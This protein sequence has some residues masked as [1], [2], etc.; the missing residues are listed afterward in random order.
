[1]SEPTSNQEPT[2]LDFRGAKVL[3]AG[4]IMIDQYWIGDTSRISPEAPVPVLKVESQEHRLGGAANAAVN[5]VSLGATATLAGIH[6]DDAAGKIYQD[7]CQQHRISMLS[8]CCQSGQT[9]TKLRMI[10]NGQ[11]LMRTDFEQDFSTAAQQSACDN[12]IAAI[13]QHDVVVISDYNKGTLTDC[14]RIIEAANA[15]NKPVIVDPKGQSFHQYSGAFL[16]TPNMLEFETVMGPCSSEQDLFTKAAQMIQQLSLQALLI[17]RSEKG[18]TLFLADGSHQHFNAEARE[19]FDVTGAGDT[20]I[21][22]L[23]TAM[24]AGM[25]LS[26]SVALANTAASLVVGKMGTSSITPLELNHALSKPQLKPGII[27][28][29]TLAEA[30]KFEQGLGKTITFTNGCFDILHAGHVQYLQEAKQLGD[31]LIVA[32]NSDASVKRLKGQERPINTLED[33]MAVLSS[34]EAVDW[35]ISFD[36]DTPESLLH[37]LQPDILVKG[38]DYDIEGVVGADI[39]IGNGGRVAVLSLQEGIST[40]RIIDSIKSQ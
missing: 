37:A 20:V 32:L 31:R 17:T 8:T 7:L 38:G 3:V 35:V 36:E 28:L 24:A 40:T 25:P 27:N 18:M 15:Q 26:D 29:A 34:L 10:S 12:I 4:D 14:Q 21:A 11:Q 39:V 19:V 22:T 1:M 2:P 13:A 30:V 33:R 6:A 23:A 16:L 9:I 5:C